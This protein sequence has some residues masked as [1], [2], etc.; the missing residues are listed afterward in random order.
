MIIFSSYIDEIHCQNHKSEIINH[1]S[2]IKKARS[3]ERAFL[4]FIL[5][6]QLRHPQSR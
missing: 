1:K 2:K 5:L 6:G 3:F 4:I